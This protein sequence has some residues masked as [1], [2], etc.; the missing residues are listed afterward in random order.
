MNNSEIK[1]F[2]HAKKSEI[3][4]ATGDNTKLFAKDTDLKKRKPDPHEL[5]LDQLQTV[6][7]DLKILSNIL[8]TYVVIKTFP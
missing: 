6:P 7:V 2:N 4:K 5:G 1:S 8:S 3:K